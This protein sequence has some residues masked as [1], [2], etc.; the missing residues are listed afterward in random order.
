MNV[1]SKA[2]V[3]HINRIKSIYRESLFGRF[4]NKLV[5]VGPPITNYLGNYNR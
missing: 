2:L 1:L 5:E 4:I 3:E